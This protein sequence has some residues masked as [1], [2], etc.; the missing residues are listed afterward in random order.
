MIAI[1]EKYIY[2][3]GYTKFPLY[4]E[5]W[6]SKKEK[7]YYANIDQ[8]QLYYY[9]YKPHRKTRFLSC[10]GL[11]NQTDKLINE[12][13][14]INRPF[15][16]IMRTTFSL[17]IALIQNNINRNKMI[18]NEEIEQR[19][20][21]SKSQY[22]FFIPTSPHIKVPIENYL[23]EVIKKQKEQ[24]L[25][26]K[27]KYK[28][29]FSFFPLSL[30]KHERRMLGSG[31]FEERRNQSISQEKSRIFN[32]NPSN[33]KKEKEKEKEKENKEKKDMDHFKGRRSEKSRTLIERKD[34]SK[35]LGNPKLKSDAH[36]EFVDNDSSSNNESKSKNNSV[37][38]TEESE[39]GKSS[40]NPS[41][42][43]N[44]NSSE[45]SDE[46]SFDKKNQLDTRLNNL[47]IV[48]PDGNKNKKN[49]I[50]SNNTDNN[51]NNYDSNNNNYDSN[52]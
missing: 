13:K 51:E 8:N 4:K 46:K 26:L 7:K 50:I 43:E 42:S 40:A 30:I 16:V 6:F 52:N 19:L 23:D 34:L 38:K 41:E 3:F 24:A 39:K 14:D 33:E 49:S 27:T 10:F 9:N 11:V 36:I 22:L 15:N 37:S 20:F 31:I 12:S 44:E 45:I 18:S 32:E 21:P 25:L 17:V 47:K 1:Y 35:E 2:N 48:N 29:K 28:G 5:D